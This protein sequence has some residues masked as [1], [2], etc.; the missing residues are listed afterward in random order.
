MCCVEDNYAISGKARSSALLTIRPDTPFFERVEA[1][2][3]EMASYDGEVAA[4]QWRQ[5]ALRLV[6]EWAGA[7]RRFLFGREPQDGVLSELAEC[8]SE[9]RS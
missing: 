4:G 1:P 7:P 3:R 5:V 9:Y 2:R 8:G 6:L